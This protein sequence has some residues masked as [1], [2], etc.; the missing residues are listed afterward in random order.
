MSNGQLFEEYYYLGHYLKTL[1]FC[2]ILIFPFSSPLHR[3][4]PFSLPFL[5]STFFPAAGALP[6]QS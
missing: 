3:L 6:P 5:P 4:S 1:S 2:V